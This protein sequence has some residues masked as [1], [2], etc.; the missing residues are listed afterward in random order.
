MIFN[1]DYFNINNLN[2]VGGQRGAKDKTHKSKLIYSQHFKTVRG[3][4]DARC[5]N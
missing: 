4:G 1:I 5:Q 2:I 3:L